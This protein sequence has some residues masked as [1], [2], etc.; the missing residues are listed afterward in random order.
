MK[1][2]KSQPGDWL[3]IEELYHRARQKL[4]RLWWWEEH[5]T[6]DSFI[7]IERDGV[8][9]GA[10][11]AWPDESPV[12]WVRLAA[13][14]AGLG[15][16][17]WLNLALPPVLD[18]L[19][20]W[21]TEKLAWMDYDGWA[22]PH[23]K[24]QGFKRLT[25]V[26]TLVKYDYTLPQTTITN[27]YIRPTA[28]A[29]IPAVATVDQAAFPPHWWHSEFTLLRRAAAASHFVVAEVADQVV[30]YAEGD[31]RLPMAHLNRIAV[32][33]A[34]QGRGVGGL[35]LDDALRSFWRLGAEHVSLNTQIDNRYSQRLYRRFG[36]EPTGDGVI[37]WELTL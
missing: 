6:A 12:A 25:K 29:D 31:L 19:R 36:F 23:L 24:A 32:Q 5:L 30:G 8:V 4:P 3:A 15:T 16:D 22:G 7:L 37:V 34:Y 11:F 21:E 20:R 33:P 10:L 17:E 9:T 35:L 18:A 1:A 26:I 14:D 27:A 28:D 2:R 13:L